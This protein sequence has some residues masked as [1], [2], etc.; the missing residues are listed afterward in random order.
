MV[1]LLRLDEFH[2]LV[3]QELARNIEHWSKV[4][5]IDPKLNKMMK[6]FKYQVDY[7]V[8]TETRKA[9]ISVEKC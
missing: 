2:L 4:T 5:E 9:E 1:N 8:F 7:L 6:L 3:E